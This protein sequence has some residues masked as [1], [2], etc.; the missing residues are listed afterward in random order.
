[1]AAPILVAGV[2]LPGGLRD[3]RDGVLIFMTPQGPAGCEYLIN[4]PFLF[5]GVL[6]NMIH[7]LKCYLSTLRKPFY[8]PAAPGLKQLAA[9][10]LP[11]IPVTHQ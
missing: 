10:Q 11:A 6:V 9:R 7:G 2:V 4:I 3:L 5:T 8:Q 1:M